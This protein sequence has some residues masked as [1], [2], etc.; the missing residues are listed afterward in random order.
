MGPLKFVHYQDRHWF[1]AASKMHQLKLNL[2]KLDHKMWVI[3]RLM[4]PLG[5]R[6]LKPKKTGEK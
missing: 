4:D 3:T 1:V 5:L 6:M 2:F